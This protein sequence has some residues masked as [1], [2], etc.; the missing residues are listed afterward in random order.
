MSCRSIDRGL[1][2]ENPMR[3]SAYERDLQQTGIKLP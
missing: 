1:E 3:R 2:R